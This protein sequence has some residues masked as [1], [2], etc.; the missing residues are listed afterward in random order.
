M[1]FPESNYGLDIRDERKVKLN[2]VVKKEKSK[3]F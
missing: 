2:Q 3:F 1:A